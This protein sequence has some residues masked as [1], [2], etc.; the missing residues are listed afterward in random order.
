MQNRKPLV[1][2]TL[3]YEHLTD[4]ILQSLPDAQRGTVVREDFPDG[5]WSNRLIEPVAGRHVIIVSS[6]AQ[7]SQLDM[8][9][10]AMDVVK[11]R[12]AK[13]DMIAPFAG[14]QTSDVPGKLK[15]PVMFK[16]M[17][18]T[19]SAIPRAGEGNSIVHM[20][21]HSDGLPYYYEGDLFCEHLYAE[22][23]ILP[24][25]R[26]LADGQSYAVASADGGRK[27]WVQSYANNL[28]VPAAFANKRRIDG[29]HVEITEI[30][31]DVK[32]LRVILFDDMVR[33]GTTLLESA[34]AYLDGGATD[35]YAVCTHGVLPGESLSLIRSAGTIQ[36]LV[37]TDTYRRVVDLPQDN[38]FQVESIAHLLADYIKA[39]M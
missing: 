34:K 1:F 2:S 13:L 21:L 20:D 32:G 24:T 7:E 29:R 12:A 14:F 39:A 28:G 31:G 9:A 36:K 22:Q 16:T 4:L 33:T 3:G 23:V 15:K 10:M 37:V 17:A 5:E 25:I 11:K 30:I 38:F 18:R 26:R 6:T 19:I 27:N 35:V 8:I